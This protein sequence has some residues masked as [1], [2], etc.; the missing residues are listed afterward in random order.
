MRS[1]NA[2]QRLMLP[3]P[4]PSWHAMA[5]AV[6]GMPPAAYATAYSSLLAPLAAPVPAP[7]KPRETW[8]AVVVSKDPNMSGKEVAERVRKEIAPS[9]GVRLHEVRGLARGGA[10][11]RTPSSGEIRKVVANKR[12]GEIGLEVKPSP[13]QRTKL[14]V[15]NVDT[16]TIPDDF[17]NELYKNNFAE[18]MDLAAFSKAVHL[19]NTWSV[20]DGPTVNVTLNVDP[21]ALDVLD[22]GKAYIGWFAYNCRALVRTYACHRAHS[23]IDVTIVNDAASMWATYEWRV[24]VWELSDHNMITVV[25]TPTTTS[26]VESIAPVPSWNFSNARCRLFEE[27][28][29]RRST[30]LPEDF[31]QMPLDQQV[32]T[33]CRMEHIV[34]DNDDKD[35]EIAKEESS[36][37][38]CPRVVALLKGSDKDRSEPA[39]YRGICLLPVFGNVLEAIMVDRVRE[40]LPEGCRWQFGFRQ[41]RCVEDAWRHVKSSVAASSARYVLEIFVDFKEAFDNVKWSAALRRLADLGCREMRLWQSVFYGRSA[42][43]RSSAGTVNVPV[44]RGCPQGSIS[45]PFIWDLL[46]DVLLRRL[47]TYCAF[48][49]YADDLLLLI[50]GNSRAVLEGKGAQLMSI[51]ETW[52][53]EIGV[54][55]STSK[56]VIMLLPAFVSERMSFLMHVASLRER[57]AGVVG[58]LARVLRADWGFSPR[59]RRTIYAGLMVPCALFGASVWYAITA[60]QIV[61][62]RR[63]IACQRLILLGCLPVCRTVSTMALQVLAGAPPLDLAAM[64]IAVKYKLKRGYPLE[65]NDWLYGEDLADLSWQQR[66]VRIDECLL[67]KP[68]SSR[69]FRRSFCAISD[70]ISSSYRLLQPIRLYTI[71]AG[72]RL[73]RAIS[74]ISLLIAFM[75]AT[76]TLSC[77]FDATMGGATGVSATET[78]TPG[79]TLTS[80]TLRAAGLI[81]PGLRVSSARNSPDFRLL[82]FGDIELSASPD[83]LDEHLPLL[84]ELSPASSAT[85]TSSLGPSPTRVIFFAGMAS[86]EVPSQ[87]SPV[88]I[89]HS[90]ATPE[91]FQ[92]NSDLYRRTSSSHPL[93]EL[94]RRS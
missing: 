78:P 52:G 22:G 48:S 29:V 21:T 45:G 31:S 69:P 34:C 54:A 8:S 27:E 93:A 14:V 90:R 38:K 89:V 62:R 59:A 11:I 65:E 60:R 36:E 10:I 56:T 20:T 64:K 44:T 70:K 2:K 72:R 43:I 51:V 79:P 15:S 91:L 50:E 76:G 35:V 85:L 5:P 37:W 12:F 49:A 77:V 33:L 24:D 74:N 23:D 13:A 81:P 94:S 86:P 84:I 83:E 9:L 46:M 63:L 57:M 47:E 1:W 55:V 82:A 53:V 30:E 32:S 42:V 40:V 41:G 80:S 87:Y 4:T 6:V 66:M 19:E 7:R 17:M 61:A 3:P 73:L 92:H 68:A 18:H 28:M 25:V 75:A 16:E 39:S 26:T 71:T 58:A 67:Q 88:T